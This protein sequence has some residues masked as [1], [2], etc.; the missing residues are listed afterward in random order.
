MKCSITLIVHN[1]YS[2]TRMTLESLILNTK[3]PYELVVVDNSDDENTRDMLLTYS[4]KINHLILNNR[5]LGK[6]NANNIGWRISRGDYIAT[7]ENDILLSEGWLGK[8]IDYLEKVPRIGLISP[9]NHDL[10]RFERGRTETYEV[11]QMERNGKKFCIPDNGVVP[12]TVVARRNVIEE[13][14]LH[15]T[16]GCL[17][18][19]SC[20]D[21]SKR[22]RD[23]GYW[24]AYSTDT[25]CYHVDTKNL[26]YKKLVNLY[27]LDTEDYNKYKDNNT[28]IKGKNRDENLVFDFL[29]V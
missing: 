1:R 6:V 9:T 10:D 5:N 18:E 27:N 14:G 13:I 2:F 29:K 24:V 22:M 19:H 17:Y 21:F 23:A 25:E 16:G 12:G 11:R 26:I 20:P 4:E 15:R 28:Q 3:Y 7:I 8:C